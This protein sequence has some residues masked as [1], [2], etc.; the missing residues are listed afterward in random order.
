M[1]LFEVVII[2]KPTQKAA[3]EGAVEKLILGPLSVIA[4][5]ATTAGINV[6]ADTLLD[7][8]VKIDRKR[9]DVLVRPF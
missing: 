6:V 8:A 5:D 2:E 4:P 7:K 3:E 9:M 1:P